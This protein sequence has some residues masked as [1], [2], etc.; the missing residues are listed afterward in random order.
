MSLHILN[1]FCTYWWLWWI[2][3]FI[4]G[5][6]LGTVIMKKWR[7]MYE[8]LMRDTRKQKNKLAKSDETLEQYVKSEKDLK[9]QL[10]IQRGKISELEAMLKNRS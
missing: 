4:L 3:P 10:A 2:L 1:D 6:V 5:W 9:G 7:T 8:D